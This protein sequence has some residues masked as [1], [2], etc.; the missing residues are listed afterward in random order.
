MKTG[1]K[2]P[3]VRVRSLSVSYPI[4]GSLSRRRFTAVERVSFAVEEGTCYALVG[5]SG[6]GKSTVAGAIL[7]LNPI[8]SGTV[9]LGPFTLPGLG[10]NQRL[11]S[12]KR[13]KRSSRTLTSPST[14][15]TR[16]GNSLRSRW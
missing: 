14:H 6:S 12:A 16:S 3:Y 9:T 15:A 4:G 13:C 8:D 10:R 1:K 11:P 5:E 7:G 2:P